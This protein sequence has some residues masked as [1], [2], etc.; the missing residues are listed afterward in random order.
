MSKRLKL[1]T[2][3]ESFDKIHKDLAKKKSGSVK[4]PVDMMETLLMDHSTMYK[5]LES[6]GERPDTPSKVIKI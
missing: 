4:V 2:S 6:I 1:Y 5:K 3:M